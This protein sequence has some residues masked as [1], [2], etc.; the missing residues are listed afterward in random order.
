MSTACRIPLLW[1]RSKSP[2]GARA[3]SALRVDQGIGLQFQQLLRLF[4]LDRLH[5]TQLAANGASATSRA[6]DR[7]AERAGLLR[8]ALQYIVHLQHLGARGA[9]KVAD[10]VGLLLQRQ[11][12]ETEMDRAEQGREQR[13]AHHQYAAFAADVVDQP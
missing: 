8:Q 7:I 10:L 11:G 6:L 2:L 5:A 4:G 13:G 3:E 1:G 12:D 9:E